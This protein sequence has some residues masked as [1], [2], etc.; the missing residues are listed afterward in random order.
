M[1]PQRG[2]GG[3]AINDKNLQS[4]IKSRRIHTE[5]GGR[6]GG[7]GWGEDDVAGCCDCDPGQTTVFFSTCWKFHYLSAAALELGNRLLLSETR[8]VRGRCDALQVSPICSSM[9]MLVST[10]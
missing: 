7:G 5:G 4:F 2:C 9:R 6:G 8:G 10:M 3:L 1:H